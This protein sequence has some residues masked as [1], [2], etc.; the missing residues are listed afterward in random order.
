MEEVCDLIAKNWNV[1]FETEY[2]KQSFDDEQNLVKSYETVSEYVISQL[3]INIGDCITEIV[4]K[5]DITV[6]FKYK[7][8][9]FTIHEWYNSRGYAHWVVNM[10]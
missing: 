9:N 8:I 3:N 10:N 2:I 4:S 1:V 7:N 6:S 5:D